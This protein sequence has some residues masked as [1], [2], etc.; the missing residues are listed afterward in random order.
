MKLA[1][2]NIAWSQEEEADAYNL[3]EEEGI[4]HV[5]I[6]PSRQW[7]DPSQATAAE[8]HRFRQDYRARV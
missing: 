4:S 7:R 6:A 2:S 8:A 5:E 1:I 3:L